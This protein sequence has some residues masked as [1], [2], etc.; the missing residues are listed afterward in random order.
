MS[1]FPSC[2][3]NPKSILV[4]M[5]S[6]LE[7]LSS[8]MDIGVQD[9]RMVGICGMGGIGKTT[10]ART[11]YN[12]LSYQFE[13]SAFLANVR[14]V[15][16]K[17]GLVSL[18]EQLLSEILK[19][20]KVKLWN[21]YNG[22]DMIRS[23]LRFKR[24][25]IVMDDLDQLNQ[26]QKLAGKI[27]WFGSGSRILVTTRDE[28]LLISHG[29]DK[30]YKAKGLDNTEAL[31]LLSLRAFQNYQPPEEYEKLSSNVVHYAS[32]LPLALEVLG[33]FLFGKTLDEWRAALDK[34]KENPEKK[35]LDTLKISFD[36]LEDTE[37]Q[38]FLD[39]ACFF[40]GKNK[41]LVIKI[42]DGCHFYPDIGIRV[43]IDKSLIRIVGRRLLMHDLLQ[44]MGWKI[45]RQESPK[46]PGKRSRLWLY[47]DI[48]HVCTRN[49]GTED[50]EGIVL[51]LQ[52][53]KRASLSSK[54]F[55]K[56]NKLRLLI[57]HNVNFSEGLEYLSN[58]LRFLEW[59]GYPFKKFPKTF[60]SKELVEINMCYSKAKQLW[61]GVK[62]FNKLKILQ[63]SHSQSL[64]KTPDFRG[65]PNLE[66]LILEGCTELHEIDQSIGILDGLVLL[67]LKDC[68]M[69]ESVPSSLYGLKT[70]K[71]LNLSGC[72]RL[73]YMMEELERLESLEELDLSGTAI[74]QPSAS[75]SL[76]KNLKMLSL[77][78][79]QRQL[80]ETERSLLSFLPVKGS[81]LMG[82]SSLIWLDLSYCGLQEQIVPNNFSSLPSLLSLNLDGNNFH[83]LP[84]SIN[85]FPK[86]EQLHLDDCK[87]LQSLQKL[88]SNLNF[89]T[90]Q[91]CTSLE[92]LDL[93]SL[94]SLRLNLSNCFKLG[95]NQ[96]HNSF[97]FTMLRKYQKGCLSFSHRE[98]QSSAMV[99][100]EYN[101]K[102]GFDVVVP[103]NEIPEWFSHQSLWLS[104]DYCSSATIQLPPGWVDCKW[105]GFAVF[106]VFLIKDRDSSCFYDLDLACFIKIMNNT[107]KHELDSRCLSMVHYL[108]SDHTWLF[109]LSRN[110]LFDT[111]S[112]DTIRTASHIEVRFSIHG[113]ALYVKKFGLHV[114]YE[115]EVL[116]S[117][118]II[119]SPEDEN[120]GVSGGAFIKRSREDGSNYSSGRGCL[121]KEPQAKRSK[122]L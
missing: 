13:G 20:K 88:P 38:I 11:F 116:D 49:S 97:V 74:K 3:S 98:D 100:R 70:L 17:V 118:Q 53:P 45:V 39:I 51:D 61:K 6:R 24:V 46:E 112:Q 27:D 56:L 64:V 40:K 102:P 60:Q 78:G 71:I 12:S 80:P 96:T 19:E 114:V 76:F 57:F 30:I 108:E 28:H 77:R 25:L 5:D 16:S 119:I 44:E 89:V 115:E 18:Q 34:M 107:W 73:D 69:L 21:V 23:K 48:F 101:L 62:Q 58:D 75:L 90:A 95:G 94:Q 36:G 111:V 37:K 106:A 113:T 122:E 120:S 79:C 52:R 31:Q 33:S 83:T 68:K 10:I 85:A 72:L 66:E 32:G 54:A 84:A 1:S 14:E 82:F 26:L 110:K 93:C 2:P 43:L 29:V 81:N 9:V 22:M 67:N 105:M 65:A 63:L 87:M 8:Y 59:H 35:I 117:S 103:G 42:M 86:L 91:A 92:I 121:D 55:V 41:D 4:G 7:E 47:Q 99:P 109:Y 15:S 104:N 50:V